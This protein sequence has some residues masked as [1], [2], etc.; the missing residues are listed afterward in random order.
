MITPEFPPMQG[1][2]GDYTN[3]LARALKTLGVEAN[4][5][6]ST[7]AC[8]GQE[9]KPGIS[10]VSG[11]GF[12]SWRHILEQMRLQ[13]PDVLHIQ[14]QTA[15]YGMHTAINLLPLR[16][17]FCTRRPK[18]VTTFHDVKVPYLFPKAGRL[19]RVP[20]ALLAGFSDAVIV[21]NY[22]DLAEMGQADGRDGKLR[23]KF[24]ARS[25]HVIPIG[26]NIPVEPPPGYDREQWR[27]SLGIEPGETL[28]CYF[29]FLN[30]A[31]GIETLLAAFEKLLARG[32]RVKLLMAGGAFGDSDP[33]NVA[34]GRRIAEVIERSH[35]RD[36]VL[37]TGFA[38]AEKISASL[39]ASDI[40]VLPY[41]EGASLRHGTL[42]AAIGHG[43]PIVTTESLRRQGPQDHS[44]SSLLPSLEGR[45]AL[46]PPKE[47]EML[48]SAVEKLILS[49][50]ESA[51]LRRKVSELAALFAW[52]V[53]AKDTLSVYKSLVSV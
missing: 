17:H 28:L 38:E 8:A 3:L 20:A 2:V 15:G 31:K 14:Y 26:S 52:D 16:L 42:M 44:A 46:V 27:L 37:W 36:L 22:E 19:R 13:R 25:L 12:G 34:Y 11:W 49:E 23:T 29:G 45:V 5:I 7:R 40:C 9:A 18:I 4:V 1:G 53:I 39:L 21:T 43:L 33:T 48:A 51:N 32:R 6:T 24:R 35:Y 47:P 50:A 10:Y 41:D 30:S